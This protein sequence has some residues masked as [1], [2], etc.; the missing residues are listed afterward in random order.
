MVRKKNNINPT[1]IENLNVH[2]CLGWGKISSVG[3]QSFKKLLEVAVPV[4]SRR[5]CEVAMFPWITDDMI[6]AGGQR[7]KDACGVSWVDQRFEWRHSYCWSGLLHLPQIFLNRETLG[8][9][10]PT[11]AA[12]ST[13]SLAPPAGEGGA[14]RTECM[15]STPA[16]HTS[17]SGLRKKWK[18]WGRLNTA[19]PG[20]ML[21]NENYDLCWF[22]F[23]TSLHKNWELFYQFDRTDKFFTVFRWDKID[24]VVEAPAPA[25]L[26]LVLVFA[27][28]P[29][30]HHPH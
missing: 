3:P 9:L 6:C 4:V 22:M 7:G 16:S 17:E 2:F 27:C 14:L 5:T 8:V 11:K 29:P 23:L 1:S 18:R 21:T 24:M 12:A 13:S 30:T 10:S 20:L 15:E 28:I 25:E 19:S 26:Q